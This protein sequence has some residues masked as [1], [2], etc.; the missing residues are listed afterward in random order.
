MTATTSAESY[1]P[2]DRIF[3]E[4]KRI[5]RK[6]TDSQIRQNE[7]T[8]QQERHFKVLLSSRRSP[9][10]TSASDS[11]DVVVNTYDPKSGGAESDEN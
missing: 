7:K 4:S 2:K 1:D 9:P 6:I 3:P 5:V 10:W 11:P 8:G